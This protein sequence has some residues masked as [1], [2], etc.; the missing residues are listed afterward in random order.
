MAEK[1]LID[2]DEKQLIIQALKM[3]HDSQFTPAVYEHSVF[4]KA[5]LLLESTVD[6]VEVVRCR[7][8]RF[9]RNH[10]TSDK[11]KLCTNKNW[12]TEYHP[13]VN[14]NDFCSYGERRTDG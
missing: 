8:C 7:D 9:C 10:P 6:A 13:F 12:N 4:G 2:A 14:D 1:R 5:A 11:V 3:H